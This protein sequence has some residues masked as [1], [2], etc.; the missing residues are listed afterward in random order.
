[1]VVKFPCKIWNKAV[2]NNHH[3]VQCDR[4]HLWVRIKCNRINLQTYKYLQKSSYAWYCPKCY[5]SIIPFT[6]ISNEKLYQTNQGCKIKLTAVTKKASEPYELTPLMEST[7]NNLS[8]LHLNISSLCYHTEELTTL[9][10]EHKL[11]FD[12]TGISES[13]LKLNKI[14]LNFVQIPGYKFGFTPIECNNGGTA[15]YTKKGLHYKLRNDLQIYKSNE[16]ESTFI[17]ITQNKEITVVCCICRHPSM[18]LL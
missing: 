18:E 5:E 13:R 3:A 7:T 15:I 1:M 12:I 9:I 10:S 2:A 6:T 11:T 16:L 8:F 17:E 4:C 14:N